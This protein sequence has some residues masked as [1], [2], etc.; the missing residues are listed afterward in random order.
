MRLLLAL[1][2]LFMPAAGEAQTIRALFVGI[3]TYEFSANPDRK[4]SFKDLQ[5]AVGDSFR[6]KEAIQQLYKVDV[7][8]LTKEAVTIDNCKGENANSITLVNFCAKRAAIEEAIEKLM[9]RSK[10][11]DTILFY[12]AGHGSQYADDRDF[13]QASGFNGTILASNARDP[14]GPVKGEI[15]DVELKEIKDRATAA[16]VHFVTIFDSCNSGTATRDGASGQSR[17]VPILR[18]KLPRRGARPTPVG[19]GGGYWTHLAAAQD[20]EQAQEVGAVGKREGVFT[21]A[22]IESMFALRGGTFG[23]YIRETRARVARGGRSSQTPVAEGMLTATLGLGA[24]RAAFFAGKRTGGEVVLDAGRLSGM[25]LGSDIAFHAS[26]ADALASNPTPLA[27]GRI[28]AVEDFTARVALDGAPP[29]TL[30]TDLV[31]V[32]T[33][34]AHGDLKLAVGNI[35][36]A[37]ADRKSAQEVLDALPFVSK[38]GAAVVQIGSHPGKRGEAV[39]MG[40]DGTAIGDL[41][42]VSAIDFGDRLKSKLL[43]VQ[44]AQQFLALAEASRAAQNPVR[45]CIDDSVYPAVTD[46]CPPMEKG[47]IRLL[48]R[49]VESIVTV[50]N[51]G[52]APMYYYVFGIDPTFGVA[53]ILPPPGG[54]DSKVAPLQPYRI[55]D[56][57]V[58]PTATGKYHFVTIATEERINTGALE[59]DGTNSR[60]GASCRP[61]LE[62]LL[63]DANR[64]VRDPSVPRIGHWQAIVETVIVQ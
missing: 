26:E 3:D 23:D 41:G 33:N 56:D 13:A 19:P 11:G 2:L 39:L 59:Q 10:P 48:K 64:G 54:Q 12:F 27:S 46:G 53:L 38:Q 61:G 24:K 36:K 62:R 15:L 50:N 6:F 1:V 63:C 30:I 52:S 5:G 34:H 43:K 58:V 60:S 31:A 14:S 17:N 8:A 7:D 35:L 57:P 20:G 49:N 40:S 45:F 37:A 51:E 55:P 4:A 47:Q 32:E 16:G 21:T 22:L 9:A 29:A 28:V 25:T 18:A 44:R 42:P